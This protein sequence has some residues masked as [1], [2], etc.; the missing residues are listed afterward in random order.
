MIEPEIPFRFNEIFP[1][2]SDI[3]KI[4]KEMTEFKSIKLYI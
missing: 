4:R 3:L 1:M 2:T